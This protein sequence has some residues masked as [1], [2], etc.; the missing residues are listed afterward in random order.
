[1]IAVLQ[2]VSSASVT[3]NNQLI[4]KIEKG[5]CVFLGVCQNDS[6]ADAAFLAD[7]MAGFRI[8]SDT[9]GK[10]NLSVADV[11]GEILLIS[12]FTLCGD[13]LKGRRPSFIKAADPK[14]GKFLYDYVAKKLRSEQLDVKCGEFGAMMDIALVND[15][16]VTF[17]LD[18][19]E[20]IK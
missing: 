5:L 10:M 13:W 14:L 17:V 2:R 6:E 8:F 16:P 7:K 15:G 3:V 4:N 12:Q 9:D 20:K 19:K 1:M 11:E 18:S